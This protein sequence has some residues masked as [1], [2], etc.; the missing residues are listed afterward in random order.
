MLKTNCF[1]IGVYFTVAFAAAQQINIQ[2]IDQ[3]PEF[4]EPYEMRDWHQVAVDYDNLVFD[5][6]AT[7]EYM[8]LVK[9]YSSGVNYPDQGGQNI[10][11]FQSGT[12]MPHIGLNTKIRM[13]GII[14]T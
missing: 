4:P 11:S 1:L 5:T 12:L 3:M 13:S 9:V 8:P 7:G 2:R 10:Y 14:D 6:L